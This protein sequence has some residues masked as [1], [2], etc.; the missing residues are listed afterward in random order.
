VNVHDYERFPVGFIKPLRR[1]FDAFK[2]SH[3]DKVGR[4]HQKH[5]EQETSSQARPD[6]QAPGPQKLT[7]RT[8][9]Y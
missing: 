5:D 1:N 9:P 3:R 6:V 2:L 4:A 8:S 7:E